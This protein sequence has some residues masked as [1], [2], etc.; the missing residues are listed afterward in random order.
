MYKINA[1]NININQ[2]M[3]KITAAVLLTMP[4]QLSYI[5]ETTINL[6]LFV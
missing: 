6:N 4:V 2:D 3:V 1:V 5:S